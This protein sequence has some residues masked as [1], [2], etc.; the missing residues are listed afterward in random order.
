MKP[1]LWS[2]ATW[3]PASAGHVNDSGG[4]QVR[5]EGQRGLKVSAGSPTLAP[6]HQPVCAAGQGCTATCW[7]ARQRDG[8]DT[9]SPP[10]SPRR[11]PGGRLATGSAR[12]LE[13]TQQQQQGASATPRSTV[14]HPGR[15]PWMARGCLGGGE[16]ITR[17]SVQLVMAGC[18]WDWACTLI[19]RGGECGGG[20]GPREGGEENLRLA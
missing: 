1:H 18:S 3:I 13:W 12:L 7:A 8:G 9:C 5:P 2:D 10:P 19:A 16:N 20:Q 14:R 11:G 6:P 4:G 15:S 17:W